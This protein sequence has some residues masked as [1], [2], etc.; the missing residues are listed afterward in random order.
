MLAKALLWSASMGVACVEQHFEGR[1][2]VAFTAADAE[3][4]LEPS[5][6]LRGCRLS[7]HYARYITLPR[8]LEVGTKLH[9]QA[10][11]SSA[12]F[13]QTAIYNMSFPATTNH[14]VVV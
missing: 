14:T 5:K 10:G 7:M 9:C 2:S 3:S 8:Y 11:T 6:L 4:K 1:G 13:I 12:T